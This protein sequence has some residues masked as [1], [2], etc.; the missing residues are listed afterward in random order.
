MPTL[1]V[2][3][4]ALRAKHGAQQFD[5]AAKKIQRGARGIDKDVIRTQKGLGGLASQFKTVAVAAGG[6]MMLYKVGGLLKSSV[7][8]M[9]KYELELANISTMLD[10]TSMKYMP[11]YKAELGKLAV[12]Y[13]EATTTLSKGLYDILSASVDAAEA[14]DVLDVAAR[15]AKAG[16]TDTGKAADILTTIINAYGM[17]A[18]QAEEISDILF[19]TV[20]RGKTTFDELASSMGM[21]VSL[22]A[23]AGLSIQEVSAALATMT[24]AGISTDMAMTSLRGILTTFLSPTKQNIVAAKELGL[25]LN[26]NTLR[27]IGLTGAVKK[28]NG[29]SAEQISA[30]FSNVRALT[31]L[32]ALLQGTE[33]HMID[34]GAATDSTGKTLEAFGKVSDTVSFKL[35]QFREEWKATKRVFGEELKPSLT[36]ALW[37]LRKVMED[38][39]LGVSDIGPAIKSVSAPFVDFAGDVLLLTGRVAGLN[40]EWRELSDNLVDAGEATNYLAEKLL[41]LDWNLKTVTTSVQDSTTEWEDFTQQ[42]FNAGASMEMLEK[43]GVSAEKRLAM[44]TANSLRQMEKK[45]KITDETTLKFIEN[46]KKEAKA[47]KDRFAVLIKEVQFEQELAYLTNEEQERAIKLRELETATKVLGTTASGKLRDAYIKELDVLQEIE[48]TKKRAGKIAEATEQTQQLLRE[49]QLEQEVLYLTNEE[50]ERAVKLQELET[51]AKI[52]GADASEKLKTEYIAE[53]KKLQDM[54]EM[55]VLVDKVRTGVG[56]L[57]RAP[58]TALMDETR[59]MG[60][61][62]EDVL[63]DIGMSVLETLYQETI[64]KP[65]EDL[66]MKSIS[67]MTAPIADALSNLLGG[68]AGGLMTGI[69]SMIGGAFFAEK[70]LVVNN[71]RVT[72]FDR[73]GLINKPTIFPMANGMGLMGEKGTEAV[74]PLSRDESGRLGVRAEMPQTGTSLKI[75]NVLDESVFEDYLSTGAGEKAVVNIMRRNRD[76]IKEVTF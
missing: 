28:L 34:L 45:G 27:T 61:V 36:P 50:R 6:M 51:A 54:K 67:K 37:V 11:R 30:V 15:A 46:A 26:A 68:I 19:A 53:L 22:S 69:G 39:A 62:L 55:K 42:M 65:L 1:D 33:G 12:E 71:G 41:G 14:L 38:L 76:E 48:E 25:E 7:Q 24:R 32:A 49:V 21:V 75:V 23:T 13:G 20:K 40:P 3:I 31:G 8:E 63:R 43:L 58:L 10:E 73:G 57:V 47:A 52:L 9:A 17:S 64:T 29:A 72:T 60:D 56:D 2:A 74:M 18:D 4:N 16:I 44:T 59:D 70:G 66:L 35:A 5:D